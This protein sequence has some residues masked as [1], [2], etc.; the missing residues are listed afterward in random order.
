MLSL[1]SIYD[2][3]PIPSQVVLF[4]DALE[5][6]PARD[7]VAIAA[8]DVTRIRHAWSAC[9][10]AAFAHGLRDPVDGAELAACQW[11]DR[12]MAR[13]GSGE[14][15]VA[16]DLTRDVIGRLRLLGQCVATAIVV[17]DAVPRDTYEMATAPV[18]GFVPV[19]E[20][21]A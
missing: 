4:F 5:Q 20:P 1:R 16:E 17:R 19:P 2:V 15:S 13:F 6:L 9:T 18:Y 21:G 7:L 10:K 8:C 12:R 14:P 11:A 3:P